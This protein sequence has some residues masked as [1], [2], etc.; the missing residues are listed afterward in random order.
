MPKEK[1]ILVIASKLKDVVKEASCQSAGDLVEAVSE[2][3]HE[4]LAAAVKRAKENGRAT[5][6]PCDL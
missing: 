2:K 3:V 4:L 6:R 1:E 5:V